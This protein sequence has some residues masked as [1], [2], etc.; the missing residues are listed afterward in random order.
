MVSNVN[1]ITVNYEEDGVL[2]V[3]E[4]DKEILSKGAW[5]TI[6]F[7]Y[8]QWDRAKETYGPVRYTIRRYR[9]MHDEY[10]QQGKFNISSDEQARKIID[11]LQRWLASAGPSVPGDSSDESEES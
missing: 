2:V 9:K 8:V 7:K 10:R 5:C 6:L 11:S 3:K 4:I 1:D